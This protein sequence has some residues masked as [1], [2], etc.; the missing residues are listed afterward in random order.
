MSVIKN[1]FQITYASINQD[2][3][4]TTFHTMLAAAQNN[5]ISDTSGNCAMM[6][7][8]I[9]ATCDWA[10]LI[11]C[12]YGDLRRAPKTVFVHHLMLAHFAKIILPFISKEYKFVLVTS[13][14]DQ[15]IPT[16]RGDKRFHVLDGFAESDDGGPL[17][18]LLTTHPQI[19]HWYCE[20]HDIRHENVSTLPLGVVEGVRGMEHIDVASRIVPLEKRPIQFLVAHRTRSGLG[21]WETRVNVSRLC[22]AQQQHHS[23]RESLCVLP[24]SSVRRDYRQGIPQALFVS[25]AQKVSFV[26]CVH[27]GGIDPSP[28]AW[29]ALML[30]TIPIIQ[31]S[32]LDDAY[33]QLPVAFVNDWNELFDDIDAA[34]RKLKTFHAA[35]SPYYSNPK[36]RKDVL[37]V[38]I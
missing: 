28:K 3:K 25:Q 11:P 36:L 30:G 34:H 4:Y 17:W 14:T 38:C 20:N 22:A 21:Q 33:S 12:F 19:L 13:G 32:T 37:Q 27:G 29:E 2:F 35:L 16:G 24:P 1:I 5:S 10:L 8:G 18:Q 23:R 9:A 15:T 7:R 6:P 26:A 31:H